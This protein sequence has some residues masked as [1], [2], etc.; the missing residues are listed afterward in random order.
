MRFAC[1]AWI[2]LRSRACVQ[3]HP[4]SSRVCL[5]VLRPRHFAPLRDA[6]VVDGMAGANGPQAVDADGQGMDAYISL[7]PKA[8]IVE[9]AAEEDKLQIS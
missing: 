5:L 3:R 2:C 4:S 6:R 8:Q 9:H 7:S 1:N